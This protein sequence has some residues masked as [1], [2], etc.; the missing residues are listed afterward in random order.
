METLGLTPFFVGPAHL[1]HQD[2]SRRERDVRIFRISASVMPH[3]PNDGSI[4][5]RIGLDSVGNAPMVSVEEIIRNDLVV[6]IGSMR[7]RAPAAIAVPSTPRCGAPW[8][9]ADRRR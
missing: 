6:V 2:I 8:F 5:Q 9:G 4:L 3:R 7:E 1:T